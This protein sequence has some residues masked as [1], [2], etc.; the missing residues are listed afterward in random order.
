[1]ELEK[2]LNEK[3]P[4]KN[5]DHGK[6]NGKFK[7]K[8]NED[9]KPVYNNNK[10]HKKWQLQDGKEYSKIFFPHQKHCPKTTDG[11]QMC[12]KFL[13]RGFCEASCTR[14][15]KLPKKMKQTSINFIVNPLTRKGKTQTRIFDSGQTV[16]DS[17]IDSFAP[18]SSI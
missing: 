16:T 18:Q 15:H 8:Q 5:E 9:Q 14:A 4:D 17:I 10:N 2:K 1:L 11:K 7:N 13:I 3:D 6:G 12:M